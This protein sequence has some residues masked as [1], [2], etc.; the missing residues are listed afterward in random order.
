MGGN[1]D[2]AL[3]VLMLV[4]ETDGPLLRANADLVAQHQECRWH[5][6]RH[7]VWWLIIAVLRGV[8]DLDVVL[9]DHPA[10]SCHGWCQ[11]HSP[12]EVVDA[13]LQDLHKMID[14]VLSALLEGTQDILG[15]LMDVDVVVAGDA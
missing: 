12:E 4:G 7:P 3:F 11:A 6:R 1:V 10:G 8:A 5:I 13:A 9:S 2:L 15:Q 14:W